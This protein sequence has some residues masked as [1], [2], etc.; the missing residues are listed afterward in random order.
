MKRPLDSSPTTAISWRTYPAGHAE[1]RAYRF[2]SKHH[3]VAVLTHTRSSTLKAQLSMVNQSHAGIHRIA[4][5][6]A[7]V[8]GVPYTHGDQ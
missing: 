1:A 6:F 4:A 8:S 3:L 7:T 5:C 2:R